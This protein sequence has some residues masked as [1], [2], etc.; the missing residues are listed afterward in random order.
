MGIVWASGCFGL[1]EIL[2][3]RI[4]ENAVCLIRR[5]TRWALEIQSLSASLAEL[6]SF[7][8]LEL[9][10]QA[11]HIP[12]VSFLSLESAPGEGRLEPSTP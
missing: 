1:P 2:A 10:F 4:T 8:I 5:A 3:A 12:I 9:A 6:G 7:S 11:A